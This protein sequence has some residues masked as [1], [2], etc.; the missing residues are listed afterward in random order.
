[1]PPRPPP[2][3][4]A[5]VK[6]GTGAQRE[7]PPCA[8]GLV[9]A[10]PG[11]WQA[12]P[13]RHAVARVH[14]GTTAL[15]PAP[16]AA[17]FRAPALRST[18]LRPQQVQRWYL[19]GTT[20]C[21]YRL[22]RALMPCPSPCSPRSHRALRGSSVRVAC[23]LS[24][25]PAGMVPPRWSRR[26]PVLACVLLGGSGLPVATPRLPVKVRVHRVRTALK[27][28]P[29]RTRKCAR[30]GGGEQAAAWMPRVM[31]CAC[32]G[33]TAASVASPPAVLRATHRRSTA[34]RAATPPPSP[35][36]VC[37]APSSRMGTGCVKMACTV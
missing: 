16:Q 23:V 12:V 4:L 32:Q 8:S 21:R 10:A 18:V 33:T 13:T 19:P 34:L 37:T 26:P 14:R 30:L 6:P 36:P 3:V 2:A 31:G 35:S 25:L 11:A 27:A 22:L 28:A 9:L 24:V 7:A 5:C 1:M 20:V 15:S 29:P 17:D